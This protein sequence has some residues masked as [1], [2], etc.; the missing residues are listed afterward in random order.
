MYTYSDAN[1]AAMMG[2]YLC[3]GLPRSIVMHH[4]LMAMMCW[5]GITPVGNTRIDHGPA[6][7]S[8]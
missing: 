1:R 8:R 7:A 2:T 5:A 3:V 4:L 6:G